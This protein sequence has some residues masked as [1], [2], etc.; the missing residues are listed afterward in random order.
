MAKGRI[1]PEDLQAL[2]DRADIVEV[3]A[4]HMKLRKAGRVFKGLCCFHQEK[5]PSFTVDPSKGLYYCHGC[6]K[7]GDVFRFLQETDGLDFSESAQ[8]LADRFGVNL[9]FE[10]PAEPVGQRAALLL[11]NKKAAEYFAALLTKSPEAEAARRY[12]QGRGFSPKDAQHWNLGFA[13]RGRDSLF[14]HL[15]AAGLAPQHVVDAGLAFVN[16]DG[17]HRDRFRGRVTFPISGLTGDVIGFGAR[18]MGDDQPKYL[19]SPETSLYQKSRVLWALDK[20][21]AEIVRSGFALV[22]EGY[23]DVMALHKVGFSNAVATCGTA[24]GEEHFALLKRFCER[25]VLAFDADA[26]GAVASERG[27]GIHAKV[28]LEV[29]VAPLPGG[30]D[31]ADVALE[32]GREAVEPLIAGA[33]PLMR[34]VLEREIGR[35]S[36]DSA[37]GKSKAIR[38][39]VERLS[40]EPNPVARGQHAQ[41]V[42]ERVGVGQYQVETVMR[43]VAQAGSA[44]TFAPSRRAGLR[45][46]PGHVKV[47]R[48]ALGILL[49]SPDGLPRAMEVL[50]PD[51]FTQP[52]HRVLFSALAGVAADPAGGS[53]MDRLPDDDARRFA[54][55]LAMAPPITRDPEEV[56]LRL[57]EFRI[58]RQIEGLKAKLD[59]LDPEGDADSYDETFQELMRLDV[60]RRKFDDK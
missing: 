11:A 39:A 7:G 21:K 4:G 2:R 52:E 56:F 19:N 53:V 3:V 25:V 38:A 18:A 29:L 43:E 17:G 44:E 34:F 8:R 58:V 31:P 48:E 33:I 46:W 37:E 30:K 23:T 50:R 5:T 13:P 24:L 49:D 12:I 9:R 41:W 27:F 16:E 32:G 55:E 36:L 14:R 10:G 57:E 22:T 6:G 20:A 1:A 59:G 35:H 60:E 15:L 54:A 47:E 42:A 45:R 26:A 28:G 51:H 40:W